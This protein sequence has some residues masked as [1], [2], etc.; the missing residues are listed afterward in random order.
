MYHNSFTEKEY[1]KALQESARVLK[2]NG[3]I[4][5]NIFTS[6][7][8]GTEAEI[9]N[10]KDHVYVTKDTLLM[11]LFSKTEFLAKAKKFSLLPFS[12]L[13]EYESDVTTGKRSVLRGI[14]I[15]LNN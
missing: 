4:C 6:K 11:V 12:E 1:D 9:K 13:I 15:K 7:Y 8:I 5:F 3:L 10:I 14:L 2:N